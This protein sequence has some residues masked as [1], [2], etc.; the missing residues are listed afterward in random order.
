MVRAASE[1]SAVSYEDTNSDIDDMN[2]N[3]AIPWSFL[4]YTKTHHIFLLFSIL[5]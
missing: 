5:H 1:K 2:F 4:G 3:I